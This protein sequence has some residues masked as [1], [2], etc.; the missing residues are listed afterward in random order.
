MS[1]F[2]SNRVNHFLRARIAPFKPASTRPGVAGPVARLPPAVRHRSSGRCPRLSHQHPLR[3]RQKPNPG[4]ATGRRTYQI[5][6]LCTDHLTGLPRGGVRPLVTENYERK[7]PSQL[8]LF[9]LEYSPS[10]SFH[11]TLNLSFHNTE[12]NII[13]SCLLFQ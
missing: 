3:R 6:Q 7:K 13:I 1:H 9:K 2:E 4:P 8:Y 11:A 5:P 12:L 10:P